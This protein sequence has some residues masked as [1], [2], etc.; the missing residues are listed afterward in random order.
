MGDILLA[1]RIPMLGKFGYVARIAQPGDS[2]AKMNKRKQSELLFK[3]ANHVIPTGIYGHVA[4][5]AGLPQDFPHYCL[6]GTGCRF[7][8]VDGK[9]WLIYVR[10]WLGAAWLP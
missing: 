1:G 9:E 8:D 2:H 3:R 6:S 5:G 4:P 10:I 7:T